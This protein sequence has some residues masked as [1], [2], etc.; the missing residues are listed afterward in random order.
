[1]LSSFFV[2]STFITQSAPF[3]SDL[4]CEWK[5]CGW[6]WTSFFMYFFL[7][8]SSSPCHAWFYKVAQIICLELPEQMSCHTFGKSF[9]L[10]LD[11]FHFYYI[12]FWKR[13]SRNAYSAQDADSPWVTTV[14]PLFLAQ[15]S[16]PFSLL[17]CRFLITEPKFLKLF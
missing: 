12:L 6:C 16:S 17:F 2:A 11:L 14:W 7:V 15:W 9:H 3:L 10:C 1:M 5:K 8:Y 4:L 13:K